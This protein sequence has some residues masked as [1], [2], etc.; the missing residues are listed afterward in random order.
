MEHD[1][2]PYVD[3]GNIDGTRCLVP[4]KVPCGEVLPDLSGE[5]SERS[6]EGASSRPVAF[7]LDEPMAAAAFWPSVLPTCNRLGGRSDEELVLDTTDSVGLPGLSNA[8]GRLNPAVCEDS[9]NGEAALRWSRTPG[10]RPRDDPEALSVASLRRRSSYGVAPWSILDA[11]L[12]LGVPG[13]GVRKEPVSNVDR[14][15]DITR[16]DRGV[17]SVL[18]DF[19]KTV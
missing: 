5:P 16:D 17:R 19:R 12:I 3:I 7:A 6:L 15:G 11:R 18:R 8:N 13:V 1:A 2:I 10:V 9:G 4:R 14:S